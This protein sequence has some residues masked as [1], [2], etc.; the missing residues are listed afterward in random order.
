[1]DI[2]AKIIIRVHYV[3]IKRRL[4]F[5]VENLKL[6]Q[7]FNRKSDPKLSSD[8]QKNL[9]KKLLIALF[10]FFFEQCVYGIFTPKNCSMAPTKIDGIL[11][12]GKEKRMFLSPPSFWLFFI[13]ISLFFFFFFLVMP[14]APTIYY[15]QKRC[16]TRRQVFQIRYVNM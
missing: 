2:N 4:F 14:F 12:V 3:H 7:F 6:N 16:Q 15:G 10:E 8:A 9:S 13:H 5:S 1:M 11:T